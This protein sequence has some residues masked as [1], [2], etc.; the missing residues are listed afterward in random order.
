MRRRNSFGALAACALLSASFFLVSNAWAQGERRKPS[1]RVTNP[2]AP[3][4][5]G[6]QPTPAP[7]EPTLVSTADEA[8]QEDEPPRRTNRTRRGAQ[9]DDTRR[10]LEAVTAEVERLSK[11]MSA[12]ERQRRTDLVEE[13]LTRAEQRAEGLQ[14]QLR[15]VLEKQANT[16]AQVERVDEQLRPENIDRTLALVGTFRPDEARDNLRRQLEN[17]KR[18]LQALMDVLD[19][20]RQRLEASLAHADDA[21]ARLRTEY[22][23]ARRK[24]GEEG[25]DAE[26]TERA[27]RPAAGRTTAAPAETSPPPPEQ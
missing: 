6:P 17:E 4:Q 23:E 8:A 1:R 2:V 20:N 7:Q 13:R 15:D 18:R 27:P 16:Q 11:Q 3:R 25:T 12:M 9:P 26:R 22:E 24:E 10:T 19:K 5:V 21:V 14:A